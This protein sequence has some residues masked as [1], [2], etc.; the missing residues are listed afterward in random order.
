MKKVVRRAAA[1]GGL[2]LAQLSGCGLSEPTEALESQAVVLGGQP[3]LSLFRE[4]WTGEGASYNDRRSATSSVFVDV[5]RGEGTADP[6][7]FLVFH[8]SD[9]DPTSFT[10]LPDRGCYHTRGSSVTLFSTIRGADFTSNGRTA[11][12]TTDLAHA[13]QVQAYIATWDDVAGTYDS[14]TSN[15]S[16]EVF[17]LTWS[18]DGRQTQFHSG[19]DELRIDQLRIH[20]NGVYRERSAVVQGTAFGAPVATSNASFRT[21]QNSHTV[22]EVFRESGGP[23]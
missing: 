20:T 17:D 18:S 13:I 8:R 21:S 22:R 12:L 7:T 14:S 10:C 5:F 3:P 19:V 4:R 16:T 9:I 1:V 6:R 23:R 11:R 2:L 15:S